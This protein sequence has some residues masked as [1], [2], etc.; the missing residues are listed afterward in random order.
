[1]TNPAKE[2][3]LVVGG[4]GYIGSHMV[5]ALLASGYRVVILDNLSTGNRRLIIGGE[6]VQGD[7]GDAA[8]LDHL[9]AEHRIDAVMH[10]AAFSLVGESVTDPIKYYRN[11][12]AGTAQLVDAMLRHRVRHFIFSSTAAVYGEPRAVPID[13]DHPCQPTNPYGATKLAVERMLRDCAD[14]YDFNF[15]SLRYFNAAGADPSGAIGEMHDPESHLIPLLL[16]VANG[17][18]A[19]IKIFGNDYPTPDGTCLRDYVHVNDLAAAHLLALRRIIDRGGAATYNLGNSKGYS[20]M[21]VLAVA[22][23]ITGHPIP[24]VVEPRRKGDPAV[25]VADSR[26][27]RAELGWQPRFE[28]IEEIVRTAWKWHN[29]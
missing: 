12:V 24:A 9:F 2:T 6:F 16:K 29:S 14:A 26:K 17:Q 3:I 13:E 8:L 11:N 23:T 10:F 20:V 19:C 21:Q 15:V 18:R 1:M 4:A 25:L 28:R 7:L 5:Q 27:I 22:R